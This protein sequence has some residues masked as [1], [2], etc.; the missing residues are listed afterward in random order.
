M[1]LVVALER[2]LRDVGEI[3][4]VSTFIIQREV[5]ILRDKNQAGRDAMPPN[6]SSIEPRGFDP[7]SKNTHSIISRFLGKEAAEKQNETAR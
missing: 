4:H 6:I 2:L 7:L 3:S 1:T 5:R